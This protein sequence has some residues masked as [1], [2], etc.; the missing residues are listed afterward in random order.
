MQTYVD[1]GKPG[2]DTVH[3]TFFVPSGSEL[4]IASA[5]A[6]ELTPSGGTRALKLLRFDKGHF[7]ANVDLTAGRWTFLIDATPRAGAAVAAHFSHTISRGG[8]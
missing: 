8:T 6:M 4:A 2:R 7:A 3:F 5:R 1:P